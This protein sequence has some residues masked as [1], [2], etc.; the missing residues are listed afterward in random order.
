MRRFGAMLYMTPLQRAT[1]SSTTPKSVMKTRVGGCCW[2]GSGP[3]ANKKRGIA[4]THHKQR[5][6]ARFAAWVRV[7]RI[8]LT[9]E[10]TTSLLGIQ[11]TAT[12]EPGATSNNV[13]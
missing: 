11:K 2:A 7:I 12:C 5:I 6:R 13:V 9:P 8:A 10:K 1:E 4:V 3:A